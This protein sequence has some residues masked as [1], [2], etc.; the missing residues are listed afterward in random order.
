LSFSVWKFTF[1]DRKLSFSVWKSSFAVWNAGFPIPHLGADL[2][3]SFWLTT[4]SAILVKKRQFSG[5]RQRENGP[6]WLNP[7]F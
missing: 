2:W 7:D 3:K 5:R 4:I 6:I 1:A